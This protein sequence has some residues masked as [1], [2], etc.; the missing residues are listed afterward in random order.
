MSSQ[1]Q[2]KPLAPLFE[3]RERLAQ[4]RYADRQKL[5]REIDRLFA[6]SA[7]GS[8]F[9]RRVEALRSSIDTSIAQVERLR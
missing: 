7:Q 2:N 9:E 4:T 1:P 6:R 3:L 5:A 8:D